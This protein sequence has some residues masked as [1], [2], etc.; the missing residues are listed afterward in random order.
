MLAVI[1]AVAPV[2]ALIIYF[3]HKDKYD[4]EP[5]SLLIKAFFG[6]FFVTFLVLIVQL[7][8][9]FALAQTKGVI[10]RI[11]LFSFVIA[12]IIEEGFKFL[13]F[14]LLIYKNKEFNEPYDGI[15]YAVMI[16]L[17]FA[18][19]ENLCYVILFYF[20]LGLVGMFSVG[21]QRAILAVPMHALAGV[22][23][24]YYFGMAKFT[25]L[26]KVHPVRNLFLMGQASEV[27][28]ENKEADGGIELPS[29]YTARP[30][31]KEFSNGV[32]EC[33]SLTGFTKDKAL[34]KKYIYI[35][36][37][38]AILAHGFYNFFVLFNIIFSF[39]CL[40]ILGAFCIIFAIKAI[41]IH[42][43]NSPFKE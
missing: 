18:T 10:L 14:R 22:L 33:S 39:L 4:K 23:M 26:E 43:E 38:L 19:L 35:G 1:V 9:T 42:T 32:K 2:A 41:K 25:P 13:V 12:A 5:L 24:G 20:K 6:G 15:L 8:L 16:S 29:A 31:R 7:I 17:G 28:G 11:F 30:V 40:L 27:G 36:L 3:Y 37:G 21:L 34:E